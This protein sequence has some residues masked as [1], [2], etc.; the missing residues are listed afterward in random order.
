MLVLRKLDGNTPPLTRGGVEKDHSL[1]QEDGLFDFLKGRVGKLD[2]I[3]ITGGEPTLHKDLPEFIK[4]IK[5]LGFKIKLDTNGTNPEM[6]EKLLNVPLIRGI[7]G[8]KKYGESNNPPNPPYQ[9]GL[10]DYIAMDIKCPLEKYKNITKFKGDL[11]NIK[12]SVK[13]IMDSKLPYEFRTTVVPGIVS[14][15]DIPKMGEIIKGAR[16]WYLQGFKPDTD[17]IDKNLKKVKPYGDK[18]M[19][20]MRKIGKKFVKKCAVR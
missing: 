2:G 6:L 12:K 7:K 13:I 16:V 11:A 8:V 14:K 1:I 17:L 20:E 15:E 3:V 9:G 19:E 5:S 4:K 18:E 10:L